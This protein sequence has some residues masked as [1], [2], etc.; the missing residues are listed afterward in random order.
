MARNLPILL[1]L[2]VIIALPFVFR[3][4]PPQGAWRDGDP[5]IVIVSPHNEAIR[6]EFA[7]AFSRWHQK[8]YQRA[9]GSGQP[10]KVDWRNIGGT[11]EISRYLA[12]EYTAATKAWWTGQKKQWSPAASDDLTKSAPPT[13]ST[14]REI[15]EAYH[16]TDMPDAITSRIDLFFGGGQFDHS[17]AFDAGF[18]V[19]MVDL[20]P[21]ELFKDG[22]VDLIP[23]RVSGEIWRTSS[24]MGNVVST[25]GII[26]NVDRLRDL[27]ISTPPAQWT[28]LANFKYYGQVGLADPTKSGSIA[29]AFEMIVHQQMHDAAIRGGYSDQQIEANEQRM[30]ALMKER[31]KAYKRGDVP[32]DL[33]G[34]QDALEKGFENGLHLLQQIGANARYFT[35]SASKVPIDVSM[36]DAAV[37]MAI[38]F[39]GRYQA[40]ESKS[41][42]GTERMKFVTP[43]GGTSVSCDPIS[44]LRGAGGS[45]ERREDQALTRQVAIRFVQFVLSEQGQRLWC[46]EPGIKDSAGELI[47]PEKYTLRRLPIRRTFYPS[48]QPAIQAAHASHVAHVVDN[49]ADP[50]IDPYAVATQFVYYRRWTGDHF[51]VLRDIVRA[52]CMDSGDELKSAWR[53]AHQRAIA[54]P[55]DPSRPF[56]YPFSALPTVKIRDKEGKEATLPLTWRTAPDIRRNFES[57]EYMREWTKAFRA[58]YGAITK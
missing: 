13:E 10:V 27:G 8:N 32:D 20:L 3:Q 52:M 9:D 37:G 24:V 49:L 18:A 35:D 47:G 41:T 58:Q 22:G 38:D 43:V 44:L 29:K 16:K 6:Y 19:P 21:P 12:S 23:E 51:G 15:Y 50:T 28:D 45:A 31:G 54:S 46:Y 5:V 25:F 56:D 53:A 55:A 14:S 4:P 40:Q 26:Y 57:I 39:Y 2:A 48:T 11:T 17:A 33:R 36:G 1:L 30:G 42:D 34:Y 7:Q